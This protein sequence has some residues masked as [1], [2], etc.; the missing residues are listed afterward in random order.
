[1]TAQAL[2]PLQWKEQS[3]PTQ[4]I[5]KDQKGFYFLIYEMTTFADKGKMTVII[6]ISGNDNFP[7][8][9]PALL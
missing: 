1:M 6:A 9:C 5:K 2:V 3:R 4:P 7:I 8:S